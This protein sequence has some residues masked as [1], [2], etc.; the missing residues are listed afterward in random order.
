[1]TQ[2]VYLPSGVWF[3]LWSQAPI[4]GPCVVTAQVPPD[5]I[6]V[7]ARREAGAPLDTPWREMTTNA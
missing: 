6:P 5:R 7:Y 1:M 3:D 4:E 2:E